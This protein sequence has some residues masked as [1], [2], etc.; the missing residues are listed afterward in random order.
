MKKDR[1]TGVD[2]RVNPRRSNL[3][4]S[5]GSDEYYRIL[6]LRVQ[7]TCE[8]YMLTLLEFYDFIGKMVKKEPGGQS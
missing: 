2:R 5:Y 3:T 6:E 1:R 4:P 7:Y 8:E